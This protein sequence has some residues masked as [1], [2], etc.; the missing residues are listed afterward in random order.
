MHWV[1]R[2]LERSITMVGTY[3][4]FVLAWLSVTHSFIKKT[5]QKK[6]QQ[7]QGDMDAP[8]VKTWTHDRPSSLPEA[9]T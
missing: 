5:K 6:N 9:V 7:T 8:K 2:E 4:I 3:I 1:T